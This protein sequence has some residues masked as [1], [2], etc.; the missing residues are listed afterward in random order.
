MKKKNIGIIISVVIV[1]LGIV[2][3][4]LN[5]QM[6][7]YKER[8]VDDWYNDIMNNKE[9]ITVY[10]T[11]YC[12]HCQEYYPVISKLANKYKLNLYFFEVDTLQKENDVAYDKLMHSFEIDDFEGRV[13]FTYIMREGK[14]INSS[15]GF[16][17]R[18]NTVNFLKENEVIKD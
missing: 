2:I 1:I 13:P 15:T 9:V 18:D 5:S 6:P 16:A 7:D 8:S 11:S 3:I 17:N 14:Y 4:S 10:G 12:P